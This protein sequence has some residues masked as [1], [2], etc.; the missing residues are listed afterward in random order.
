MAA[1]LILASASPRRLELLRQIGIEPDSVEPA[2]L[3]ETPLPGELPVPH[4][5]R[6]ADAKAE[7]VARRHPQAYVLAAD[8]VVAA[9]RRILPKPEDAATARRC[10]ELLSGRRHRV[11]GGI[12][13]RAPGGRV[14]RRLS[15]TRVAFK[16]LSPAELEAY[17]AGGEWHGKAGGYA[18]QGSAAAFVPWI[19]G[20]YSNVVGLDLAAAS[21]LLEGLGWRGRERTG[22]PAR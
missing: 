7:A 20:S 21:G 13:L 3:D 6:L 4:A 14:G 16:R 15:T 12:V 2:E 18:I 10:L 5:Q 9:G 11:Q 1:P 8:T 22:E 19:E 17:L